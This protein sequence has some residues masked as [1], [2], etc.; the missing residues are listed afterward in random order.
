MRRT[1]LDFSAYISADKEH[2]PHAHLSSLSRL[3][4]KA[5]VE[6]IVG[7]CVTPNRIGTLQG[8]NNRKEMAFCSNAVS[9]IFDA[10]MQH[11]VVLEHRLP[12]ALR[13]SCFFGQ[14]RSPSLRTSL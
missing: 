14:A 8:V 5:V 4:M 1:L 9:F 10:A 11:S 6:D 7:F 2:T 13:F 12:A 3:T